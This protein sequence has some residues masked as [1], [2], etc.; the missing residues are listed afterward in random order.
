MKTIKP[1]QDFKHGRKTYKKNRKYE[2]SEEDAEYFEACGWVGDA[3]K[4]VVKRGVRA[5]GSEWLDIHDA[6]IGHSSEVN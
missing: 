6:V 5:D 2:V 3:D 4:T 1:N